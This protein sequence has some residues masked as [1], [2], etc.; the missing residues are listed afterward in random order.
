MLSNTELHI[1]LSLVTWHSPT[2]Q[3][4]CNCEDNINRIKE[5]KMP[6]PPKGEA[7]HGWAT[8]RI[9]QEVIALCPWLEILVINETLPPSSRYLSNPP[10]ALFSACQTSCF[11][12]YTAEFS[13]RTEST[14]PWRVNVFWMSP[15]PPQRWSLISW[16]A[17]LYR[18]VT[19]CSDFFGSSSRWI[20]RARRIDRGWC[21][22]IASSIGPR[23]APIGR[24]RGSRAGLILERTGGVSGIRLGAEVSRFSVR[25]VG[26]K[27]IGRSPI[28]H[29]YLLVPNLNDV[30]DMQS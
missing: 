20:P 14:S 11:S 9:P 28:E 21:A 19:R 26:V 12:R 18:S 22:A 10:S 30:F 15:P 25:S 17:R 27:S 7:C 29:F 2:R 24:G 3:L 4:R 23:T 8:F 1:Y 6:R 5:T 13:G 16:V